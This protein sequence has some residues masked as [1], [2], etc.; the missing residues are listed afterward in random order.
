MS[1]NIF[2]LFAL[3][4]FLKNKYSRNTN[5]KYICFFDVSLLII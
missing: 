1:T 4:F 2:K 3:L 5:R